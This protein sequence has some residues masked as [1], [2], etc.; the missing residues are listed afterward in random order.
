M[1]TSGAATPSSTPPRSRPVASPAAIR[2]VLNINGRLAATRTGRLQGPVSQWVEE[3][4]TFALEDGIDTFILMGDDS[5]TLARLAAEVV[6]AVRAAVTAARH[7]RSASPPPPAAGTVP[8]PVS[9]PGPRTTALGVTPTPDTG[10]RL[11]SIMRWDERTR[12]TAPAPAPDTVYTD[13]GRQVAQH[14]I[15]VHDHLRAELAKVRDIVDQV[16]DGSVS[17][18]AA[19]DE[20]AELTIRQNDWVMGAYCASYCR[21]VTTHH[22]IEDA[23]LFPHLR[24]REAGIAAVIDRLEVEHRVIHA[25]LEEV[26]AA[27]VAFVGSPG[28]FS[29]IDAAMDSLSD[30]LLSH[31]SYEEQ[32]L[33]EPLARVGMYPGQL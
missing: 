3:L 13:D 26:D 12:P 32:Q 31:L 23:S 28:D 15:D 4:S 1:A 14:L 22:S 7:D 20:I 27:L 18:G 21:T 19:R 30:T 29:A 6:P 16:Q 10:I 8:A 24:Q 11:S 17:P 33:V 5:A 25:V 9:T 2:R